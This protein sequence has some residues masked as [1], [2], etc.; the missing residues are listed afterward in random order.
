ML[1]VEMTGSV[2]TQTGKGAMRQLRM[3][4]ITPAVVYGAEKENVS[5]QFET[6]ELFQQ[7]LKINRRNAVVT[8]NIDGS[9]SRNVLVKDVQTD[10]VKDT[11]IHVD[12][13]EIDINQNRVFDVPLN[14][15]G[16]AK[17][18]DLGGIL[19]VGLSKISLEA[20][21]LDIPDQVDVEISGLNIGDGIRIGD[22]TIPEGVAV[23]TDMEKVCVSVVPAKKAAA[24]SEVD[25]VEEVE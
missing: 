3:K 12:F 24:D 21:P 23:K 4:G 20:K 2:R 16:N 8:L 17:G 5:L 7:L 15:V 9:N 18:C 25:E 11:L 19:D 13:Y 10:P 1:Q 22:V 14:F 6:K